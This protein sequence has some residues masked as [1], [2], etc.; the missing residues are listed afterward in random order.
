M[1]VILTTDEERGVWMRAPWDEAQ[2]L[3][4]PLPNDA[5]KESSGEFA[6]GLHIERKPTPRLPR[7]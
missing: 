1:P 3:H 5:L 7:D 6:F 4:R 2:A